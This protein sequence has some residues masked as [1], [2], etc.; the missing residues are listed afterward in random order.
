MVAVCVDIFCFL[1]V[2]DIDC[3]IENTSTSLYPATVCNLFV[4]PV[5]IETAV[6]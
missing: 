1:A 4:Y 6:N 3:V 5:V 2:L